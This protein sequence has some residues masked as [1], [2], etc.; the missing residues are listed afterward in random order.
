M[1][2]VSLHFPT[3]HSWTFL[4]SHTLP[5]DLSVSSSTTKA[6]EWKITRAT[7]EGSGQ[8]QAPG[9]HNRSMKTSLTASSPC[10]HTS[11]SRDLE[12][13][14]FTL[15]FSSSV[16]PYSNVLCNIFKGAQVSLAG[17]GGGDHGDEFLGGSWGFPSQLP[18]KPPRPLSSLDDRFTS[19]FQSVG[20]EN[21]IEIETP[22]LMG[23]LT[24]APTTTEGW[25]RAKEDS[26]R[27]ALMC[28]NDCA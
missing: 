23:S 10:F 1:F 5:I 18:L 17:G 15:V 9:S 2:K 8:H 25:Q 11:P 24:H 4:P 27:E 6:P 3:A 13:L 20:L 28:M 16:N 22:A 21:T 14:G 26:R 19:S 7:Q 12:K